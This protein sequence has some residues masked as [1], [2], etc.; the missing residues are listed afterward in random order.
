MCLVVYISLIPACTLYK[1]V[2]VKQPRTIGS[3]IVLHRGFYSGSSE[4]SL[5]LLL[6][7]SE[8][9]RGRLQEESQRTTKVLTMMQHSSDSN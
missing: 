1:D 2:N 8:T 4:G 3:F 7:F 6:G 9:Q 5:S